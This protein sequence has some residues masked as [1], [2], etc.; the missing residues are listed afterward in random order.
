HSRRPVAEGRDL[1]LDQGAT[2]VSDREA[3]VR[4]EDGR[5][6][7]PA[8]ALAREQVR[9]QRVGRHAAAQVLRGL[10]VVPET[11]LEAETSVA[12][13]ILDIAVVGLPIVVA[14]LVAAQH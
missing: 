13:P 3:S 4:I 6:V 9:P 2:R 12:L 7:R 8:F 5:L 14:E 1:L 11:T 10:P